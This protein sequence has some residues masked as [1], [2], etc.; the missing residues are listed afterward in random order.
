MYTAS[1]HLL[2]GPYNPTPHKPAL[3]TVSRAGMI[4][5]F[6]QDKDMRWQ[7]FKAELDSVSVPS[8]LLTHAAICPDKGV[9]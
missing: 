8:E 1:K 4:K 5:L 3:V 7:D 2:G 9:H 6:M